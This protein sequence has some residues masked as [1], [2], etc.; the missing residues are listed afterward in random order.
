MPRAARSLTLGLLCLG[1]VTCG[2]ASPAARQLGVSTASRAVQLSEAARD[3]PA[4]Q[5]AYWLGPGPSVFWAFG[6]PVPSTPWICQE[7]SVPGQGRVAFCVVTY[8]QAHPQRP[9]RP[10]EYQLVTRL[11][12][13][14]AA[15]VLVYARV[16]S[17]DP[18][19]QAVRPDPR[20]PLRADERQREPVVALHADGLDRGRRHPRLGRHQ[21]VERGARPARRDRRASASA[22]PRTTLSATIRLPGR[23]SS[24]AARSRPACPACRRR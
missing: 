9:F 5:A 18:A 11:A 3:L 1:T 8:L 6:R 2:C 16:P 24:S 13:P 15:A 17:V 12:R 20:P 10:G 21:L 19:L 4:G 14:G 7:P 23:V 22:P